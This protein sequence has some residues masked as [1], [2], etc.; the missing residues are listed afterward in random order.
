MGQGR[1]VI[2]QRSHARSHIIRPCVHEFLCGGT[3]FVQATVLWP[4]QGSRACVHSSANG[5]LTANGLDENYFSRNNPL[6]QDPLGRN[7]DKWGPSSPLLIRAG[8]DRLRA[9]GGAVPA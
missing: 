5:L 1:P 4:D 9:R 3:M 7:A 8:P 2:Y 6:L